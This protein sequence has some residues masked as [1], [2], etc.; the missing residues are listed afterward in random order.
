MA[1]HL[2][3][4]ISSSVIHCKNEEKLVALLVYS[5]F[6][7]MASSSF[8]KKSVVTGSFSQIHSSS[9]QI[10]NDYGVTPYSVQHRALVEYSE[11]F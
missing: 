4:F 3:C 10:R 8:W 9:A 7:Q 5:S 1:S 11:W 2:Q 6:K